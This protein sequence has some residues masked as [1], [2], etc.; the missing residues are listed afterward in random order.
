MTTDRHTGPCAPVC[1]DWQSRGTEPLPAVVYRRPVRP[2]GRCRCS[3]P[4]HPGTL[5]V[6]RQCTVSESCLTTQQECGIR[7]KRTVRRHPEKAAGVSFQ[8]LLQIT[9]SFPCAA[10]C[11]LLNSSP[12]QTCFLSNLKFSQTMSP[13]R[14]FCK[15]QGVH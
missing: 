3:G 11:R 9:K 12:S 1:D 13:T 10:E 7:E 15:L 5:A 2:S 8:S 4:P 6:Y 14:Q